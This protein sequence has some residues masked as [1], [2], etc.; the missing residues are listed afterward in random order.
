M[1]ALLSRPALARVSIA[2]HVHGREPQRG[3][4]ISKLAFVVIPPAFDPSCDHEGAGVTVS[5]RDGGNA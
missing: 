3:G 1:I 5:C 4:P 2:R